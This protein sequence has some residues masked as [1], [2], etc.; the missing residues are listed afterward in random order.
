MAKP[1]NF[2]LFAN[3]HAPSAASAPLLKPQ[4]V[5]TSAERSKICTASELL[6]PRTGQLAGAVYVGVWII[7]LP[8]KLAGDEKFNMA[9]PGNGVWLS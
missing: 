5:G 7:K 4:K 1:L 9:L 8:A 3:L 6:S 2:Q